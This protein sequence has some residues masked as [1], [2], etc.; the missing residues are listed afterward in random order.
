M[1]FPLRS[2][3]LVVSFLSCALVCGVARASGPV[4][5]EKMERQVATYGVGSKVKLT[6]TNHAKVEGKV[7]AIHSDSVDM[8]RAGTMTPVPVSFTDIAS[9]KSHGALR[10]RFKTGPCVGPVTLAIASPFI[11]VAALTGH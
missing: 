4:N 6:L 3:T 5:A 10:K 9:V 8:L 11:L 7:A 2:K 1:T